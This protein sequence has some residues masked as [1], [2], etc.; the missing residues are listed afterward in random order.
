LLHGNNNYH[1]DVKAKSR[2][3][4]DGILSMNWVR[5]I[6]SMP[7]VGETCRDLDIVDFIVKRDEGSSDVLV[8]LKKRKSNLLV[9][10]KFIIK[11]I[12]RFSK[13]RTSGVAK[14]I[15]VPKNRTGS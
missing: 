14:S 5:N 13:L 15:M 10:D 12:F 11:K 4:G 2:L 9:G 3:C 7:T 6:N 1:A 8:Y